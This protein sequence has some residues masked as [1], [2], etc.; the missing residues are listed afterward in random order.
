MWV[1]LPLPGHL[2]GHILKVHI[3]I[4]SLLLICVAVKLGEVEPKKDYAME[5]YNRLQI[6]IGEPASLQM[7]MRAYK[8][9]KEAE[10]KYNLTAHEIFDFIAR[11]TGYHFHIYAYHKGE[12][13]IGL[14]QMT[15]VARKSVSYFKEFEKEHWKLWDPYYNIMAGCEY[16]RICKN[17]AKETKI[18][19]LHLSE[20][21]LARGYYN[22][23]YG[24]VTSTVL[25]VL[26]YMLEDEESETNN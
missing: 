24:T 12:D 18:K 3:L 4:A 9:V 23:G 14:T 11:E 1:R 16:Y 15:P 10:I 6:H 19:R 26:N 2:E 22:G 5:I 21:E 25:P 20:I 7:K 8:A 13:A 17:W